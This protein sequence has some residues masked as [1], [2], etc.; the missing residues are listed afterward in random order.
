MP[1]WIYKRMKK[2]LKN[3]GKFG[4]YGINFSSNMSFNFTWRFY[5]CIKKVIN[6]QEVNIWNFFYVFIRHPSTQ[7]RKF[8]EK[9]SFGR[10]TLF[11]FPYTHLR[12][13]PDFFQS[14][15]VCFT[16][17]PFWWSNLSFALTRFDRLKLDPQHF[18]NWKM[19]DCSKN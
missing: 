18:P 6:S 13:D 9:F 17:F 14:W 11:F 3:T 4:L 19:T 1:L 8:W 15:T 2:Q 12:I 5:S 10:F 16:Q 7:V